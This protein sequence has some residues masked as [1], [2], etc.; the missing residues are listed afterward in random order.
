MQAITTKF[1][2]PGNVRGSRVSATAEAGR[3]SLEWDHRLNPDEN[4]KAAAVAFAR[5]F[6]WKGTLVGGHLPKS[7]SSHMAWVFTSDLSPRAEV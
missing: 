5:K 7:N 3:I 4:H 2:G 6:G 1:H